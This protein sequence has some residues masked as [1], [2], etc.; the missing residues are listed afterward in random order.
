VGAGTIAEAILKWLRA[1]S[2]QKLSPAGWA[3]VGLF[4]LHTCI[5]VAVNCGLQLTHTEQGLW[6]YG[7]C[8][9]MIMAWVV[10]VIDVLT[11]PY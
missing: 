9:P 4:A 1:S 5:I 2:R 7:I 11:W 6:I 8:I 3:L 10:V